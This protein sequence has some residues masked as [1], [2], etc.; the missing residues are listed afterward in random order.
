[1]SVCLDSRAILAWLDGDEPAMGR[2]QEL[3]ASRPVVSWVN[4]VEAMTV[5]SAT[6]AAGR[7]TRCSRACVRRLP[8]TCRGRAGWSS[9]EVEGGPADG[10]RRLLCGGD[11][12]GELVLLTGNPE[13]LAQPELPC[14]TEDLR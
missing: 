1:V 8:A 6:T 2:V 12:R 10:A 13:I 9:G 4:L 3:F 11:H 7:P 5:S 14:A